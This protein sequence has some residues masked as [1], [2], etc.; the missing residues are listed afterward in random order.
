MSCRLVR[1]NPLLREQFA[2]HILD[3]LPGI[4]FRL[5]HV[6]TLTPA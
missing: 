4:H 1:D 6:A 5:G 2:R 3:A